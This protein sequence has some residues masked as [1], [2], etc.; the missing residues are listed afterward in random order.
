MA[1]KPR[2]KPTT[3]AKLTDKAQSERFKETARNLGVEENV[4]FEKLV[5]KLAR[6]SRKEQRP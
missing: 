1:E 4:D 3:K 2:R 6:S 5:A